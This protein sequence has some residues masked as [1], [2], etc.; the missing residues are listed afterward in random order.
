MWR[1]NSSVLTSRLSPTCSF[2]TALPSPPG[3]ANRT[4][5]AFCTRIGQTLHVHVTCE[6]TTH[7][8]THTHIHIRCRCLSVFPRI[9][10]IMH[11]HVNCEFSTYPYIHKYTDK[12]TI[13]VLPRVGQIVRVNV[14]SEDY[15]CA[16]ICMY[17]RICSPIRTLLHI[18]LAFIN[19]KK[20][21]RQHQPQTDTHTYIYIYIYIHTY[22]HTHHHTHTAPAVH[23]RL[24][25]HAQI[26]H[27]DTRQLPTPAV[28]RRFHKHKGT[29]LRL[30]SS[31]NHHARL[32]LRRNREHFSAGTQ[33]WQIFGFAILCVCMYTY[34]YV[35]R[36]CKDKVREYQYI[37]TNIS[38]ACQP[39][40]WPVCMYVCTC[41]WYTCVHVSR[42]L[43]MR[44]R[45]N[46]IPHTLIYTH[47]H[48]YT[49][50][51]IYIEKLETICMYV[52]IYIYIYISCISY[53]AYIHIYTH[54]YTHT[55]HMFEYLTGQRQ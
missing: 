19:T 4:V 12:H 8:H 10:Q 27:T 28:Y 31:N 18:Y 21:T 37:H 25:T 49:C 3:I 54:T 53:R 39:F 1:A 16:C 11:V 42:L 52:Y 51:H 17:A 50:I 32:S 20:R 22:I 5:S 24:H 9:G 6:F 55:Y 35:C 23:N 41:T 47:T 38:K 15:V 40:A 36:M 2:V 7:T 33:L 43:N 30:R 26:H 29:L 13:A 46:N 48:A 34:M 45:R 44:T 14:H